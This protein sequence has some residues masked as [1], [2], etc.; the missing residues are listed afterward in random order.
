MIKRSEPRVFH[1]GGPTGAG[2][3]QF[4]LQLAER[5]GAE[6]VGA[7]AFQ[8][9]AEMPV[10]TAQ[11]TESQ[12]SRVP[13]HLV[14]CV[15][16]CDAF[17]VHQYALQARKALDDIASRSRTALVVGGTGLYFR[18]LIDGLATTPPANAELRASMTQLELSALIER[19][20]NLDPD[21]P[22]QIDLRNRRRVERAIEIVEGS[23]MPLAEFRQ[24]PRTNA[25]GLYLT[26]QRPD[27]VSRIDT[28][29]REMFERG[30][31]D[32]VAALAGPIGPTATRA[33]GFYEIQLLLRGEMN[34]DECQSAIAVATRRYAK[35]QLTWFRNQTTFQPLELTPSCP[36]AVERAL[37]ILARQ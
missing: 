23:G 11:P 19:L 9:Y 35:R 10:L 28:N 36:D 29:V 2:K 15:P 22:S 18:A 6:I 30:V 14:G 3:T 16:V 34:S 5:L 27:L 33:I 4:A 26:R 1:L 32:E 25:P 17:D 21:A 12:R 8:V 20:R 7:D 31:V 13:H 24:T 37:T